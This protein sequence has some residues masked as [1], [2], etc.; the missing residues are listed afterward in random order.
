MGSIHVPESCKTV[1]ILRCRE[2]F[3]LPSQLMTVERLMLCNTDEALRPSAESW[4]GRGNKPS[5]HQTVEDVFCSVTVNA[6]KERC[7]NDPEACVSTAAV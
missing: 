5:G 3:C 6:I 7:C 2:H 4:H 1:L